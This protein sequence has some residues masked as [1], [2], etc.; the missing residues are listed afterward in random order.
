MSVVLGEVGVDARL[1]FC[2]QV[3][4]DQVHAALA[5]PFRVRLEEVEGEQRAV[6]HGLLHIAQG[7]LAGRS[8][9]RHPA[10]GAARRAQQARLHQRR[11]D[12]PYPRRV[13]VH[14]FGNSFGGDHLGGVGRDVGQDVGGGQ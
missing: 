2:A 11:D 3:L 7:D 10:G 1:E 12:L 14:L 5:G 6:L 4:E 9:Q 13:L 8:P